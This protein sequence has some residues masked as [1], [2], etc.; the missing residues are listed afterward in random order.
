MSPL[1]QR[2]GR[3]RWLHGLVALLHIY[4]VAQ[5]FLS[6]LPLYRR[7]KPSG[8][9]YRVT[10]LDQFSIE[11]GM[12]RVEEYAPAIAGYPVKTFMDLGCNAGWFALWLT[13]RGRDR[14]SPGLLVDANPRMVAEAAWHMKRNGLANCAVV[15]GAVGVR[16]GHSQTTFHIHTS[17]TA[18]SV[19]PFQPGKQYPAK[20][21]ITDVTVPAV[22][23]G[24]EWE[25]RFGDTAV[26]LLKV[27]IEGTELDLI[28]YERTFIQKRVSRVVVEWHKWCNSLAQ[29][30]DRLVSI[31]FKRSGVY[32]ETDTV[33]VAIYE[34]VGWD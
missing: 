13:A 10:S 19:L 4:P 9:V 17:S 30:D 27:D 23:I 18:S 15:H 2:L 11:Y 22:S 12:F 5:S 33:G 29:M 14:L 7:L 16:P 3:H 26:D 8:V 6:R 25:A 1:F 32:G 21:T 20:G 31:G 28:M 34:N 24:P